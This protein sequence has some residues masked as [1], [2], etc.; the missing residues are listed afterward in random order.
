MLH[1]GFVRYIKLFGS[2]LGPVTD[3]CVTAVELHGS[4]MTVLVKQLSFTS[5]T[6][7]N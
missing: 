4:D 5:V 1:K 6:V 2:V 3:F 7:L